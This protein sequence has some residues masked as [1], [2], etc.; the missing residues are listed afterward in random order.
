MRVSHVLLRSPGHRAG[1]FLFK[2]PLYRGIRYDEPGSIAPLSHAAGLRRRPSTAATTCATAR[3]CSCWCAKTQTAHCTP[4]QGAAYLDCIKGYHPTRARKCGT[5]AN[6]SRALIADCNIRKRG[7]EMRL[8][9]MEGLVDNEMKNPQL[10]V[11]AAGGRCRRTA[12]EG[13]TH[14]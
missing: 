14:G 2:R 13:W 10:L 7:P 6:C 8:L 12:A 3:I 9:Q 11:L 1:L 4:N 5:G